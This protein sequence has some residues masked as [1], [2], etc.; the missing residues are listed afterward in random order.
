MSTITARRLLLTDGE[1]VY[2][3]NP[4]RRDAAGFVEIMREVA[5]EGLYTLAQA[6][7]VDWTIPGKRADIDE[8]ARE[9]GFL[10][11]V[12]EGHGVPVGFL[13]FEN[14]SRRRTQHVGMFSIFILRD[15]RGKGI[16]T[17]LIQTLVEWATVHPL[18]EKITLAVFANNIRAIA[19]Y[20]KYGF[21]IEGRCVRDIK[22]GD[23]YVD[24]LMMYKFV[25]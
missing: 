3:R 22:I 23:G 15:W 19:L 2:I 16:G 21:Q 4:N 8:H 5:A 14:G 17:V 25:K 12:A 18:I 7:E 20:Q 1:V 13:E 10:T 6:D 9:P 11:L 24:S